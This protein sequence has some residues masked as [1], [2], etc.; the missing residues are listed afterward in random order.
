MTRDVVKLALPR[1]RHSVDWWG[2]PT[3]LEWALAPARGV[4]VTI[5]G[6]WVSRAW[7]SGVCVGPRV[8]G[9]K[10]LESRGVATSLEAG[11]Q[12]P[13]RAPGVTPWGPL[14]EG[15]PACEFVGPHSSSDSVRSVWDTVAFGPSWQTKKIV[16]S[17]QLK[18]VEL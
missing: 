3:R 2:L 17:H 16:R 7:P 8:A 10:V 15:W 12:S 1:F 18:L 13:G 6:S 4:G 5:A 11:G 14:F 9:T